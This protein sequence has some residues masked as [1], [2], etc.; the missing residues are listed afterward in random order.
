MFHL[1]E[2]PRMKFRKLTPADE[3]LVIATSCDANVMRFITGKPR[4]AEE[5]KA[6][7]EKNL[8]LDDGRHGVFVAESKTSGDF[9][10]FFL[11]RPFEVEG[12]TETGYRL[13]EHQWGKGYATEGTFAMLQYI[14]GSLGQPFV[15][16][17]VEEAHLASRR[18]L[19]KAG[20]VFEKTGYFYNA[21]LMY[22]KI[23]REQFLSKQN[24]PSPLP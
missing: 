3:P 18:V 6:E 14:L 17:V 24:N 7:L 10:G 5:A 19:E 9:I 11:V 15:I 1:P 16:A 22:Y 12:E 13:P 2:S 20:F 23:T 8:K 21:E 4:T